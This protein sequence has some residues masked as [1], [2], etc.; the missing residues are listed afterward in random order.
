MSMHT[1]KLAGS[2]FSS[3][4]IF[5]LA[6]QDTFHRTFFFL[7]SPVLKNAL[8]H[9]QEFVSRQMT[10]FL[11][12]ALSVLFTGMFMSTALVVTAYIIIY[13]KHKFLCLLLSNWDFSN[14]LRLCATS[15]SFTVLLFSAGTQLLLL[16]LKCQM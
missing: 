5:C 14:F 10:F 13:R 8:H 4:F 12:F 3:T 16:L 11:G 1:A 15:P 7:I 6:K 9:F 2:I